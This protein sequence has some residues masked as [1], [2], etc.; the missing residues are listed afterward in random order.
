MISVFT[1]GADIGTVDAHNDSLCV[2]KL[3]PYLVL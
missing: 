3:L 2:F 1:F